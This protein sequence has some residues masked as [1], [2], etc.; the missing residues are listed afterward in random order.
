MQI[1]QI[2]FG[3]PLVLA[4][5]GL[6][7]WMKRFGVSG[8]A[9]NAASMAVGLVVGVGYQYSQAPLVGFSAW[10]GACVYGVGLGLIASGIYDAVRDATAARIIVATVN[11]DKPPA[12]E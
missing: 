12:V 9:L 4:V 10:F 7:E 1:D 6:V 5:I 11:T 2:V 3:V 8:H